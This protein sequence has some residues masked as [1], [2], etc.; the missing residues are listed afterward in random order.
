MSPKSEKAWQQKSALGYETRL[1]SP[2]RFKLETGVREVGSMTE[3]RISVGRQVEDKLITILKLPVGKTFAL[4]V[5]F[6]S[7]TTLTVS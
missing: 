3:P 2:R 7:F 1:G 4:T 5:S 6:P